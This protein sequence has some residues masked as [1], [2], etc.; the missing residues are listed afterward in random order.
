MIAIDQDVVSSAQPRTTNMPCESQ[1]EI[2]EKPGPG[3]KTSEMNSFAR[4]GVIRVHE[5]Q[6][7]KTRV[8]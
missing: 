6:M 7:K 4:F 5:I 3:P 1:F 8:H 2:P